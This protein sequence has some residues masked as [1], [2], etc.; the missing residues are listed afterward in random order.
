M[1]NP[2]NLSFKD[3]RGFSLNLFSLGA[4]VENN[5]FSLKN[6]NEYNGRFWDDQDKDNILS[7]VPSSGL[8]MNAQAEASAL[9]LSIGSFSLVSYALGVSDSE[10]PKRSISASSYWKSDERYGQ[11]EGNFW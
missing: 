1:W 11:P 3:N 10:F 2:A 4:F 8:N 5:S 7:L 9:G 6:Y